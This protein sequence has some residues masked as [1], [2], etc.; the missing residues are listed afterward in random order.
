LEK[1]VDAGADLRVKDDQG[2]D[3]LTYGILY[4]NNPEIIK[5]LIHSGADPDARDEYGTPV[6]FWA[7]AYGYDSELVLSLVSSGRRIL[8]QDKDGWTPLMGSLYFGNTPEVVASLSEL[9]P[10]GR[11]QDGF[12]R[13]L[14]EFRRVYEKN[15]Y[16][17]P[18]E[19][20]LLIDRRRIYPADAVPYG[21]DLNT[22]LLEVLRWGHDTEVVHNLI[23][24]GA[25]PDC[26][27]EDGFTALLTAAA[28]N[29]FEMV[30][31]LVD[32]GASVFSVTPY[33]WTPLHVAS[34]TSVSQT[35][36]ILIQKG[37]DV[38]VR[39]FDN[40]TPLMWAVRNGCSIDYLQYLLDAGADPEAITYTRESVLHLACSS[41]QA[42]SEELLSLL[43][44]KGADVN[45]VNRK[46]ETALFSSASMGYESVCRYLLE[47]GADPDIVDINGETSS[48]RAINN[49][50]PD[51]AE[52]IQSY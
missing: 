49:G 2:W 22:S 7:A 13:G 52:L 41:W 32:E 40:W 16:A 51:L 30:K 50:Y 44:E 8:W 46:G 26:S 38:N 23:S 45:S 43:I 12:Q 3:A 29:S 31:A 34:W 9:T 6:F 28:Y 4:Q 37:W 42:P 20:N 5:S 19:L 14:R 10:D 48:T 36:E 39:D 1:L 33:G 27:G 11:I 47:N 21:D 25:D 18:E 35:V 17:P 15:F 24:S